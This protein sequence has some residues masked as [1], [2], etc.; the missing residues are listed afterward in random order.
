MFNQIVTYIILFVEIWSQK[1][2]WQLRVIS[3]Y[4]IHRYIEKNVKLSK[5]YREWGDKNK[6]V[7]LFLHE[8]PAQLVNHCMNKI[9]MVAGHCPVVHHEGIWLERGKKRGRNV[10]IEPFF[11]SDEMPLKFT[12]VRMSICHLQDM[13]EDRTNPIRTAFL[14]KMKDLPVKGD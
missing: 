7:P 5:G 11:V 2:K 9:D 3:N 12:S 1:A 6:P 8:R 10:R 13:V 14:E 4:Y